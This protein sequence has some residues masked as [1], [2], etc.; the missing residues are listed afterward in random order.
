MRTGIT[1]LFREEADV[2]AP[3]QDEGHLRAAGNGH[4]PL[5]GRGQHHRGHRPR[6]FLIGA[7]KLSISA[8]RSSWCWSLLALAV[9]FHERLSRRGQLDRHDRVDPCAEAASG[10]GDGPR[11]SMSWPFSS[12]TSAVAD[13]RQ[14][15]H[16][17]PSS[18]TH[19]I[20][21]ALVGAIAWN[22]ITWYY[23]IP[24]SSSHAL[25]GGLVGAALVKAGPA[26]ADLERPGQDRP[27]HLCCA[28]AG[29]A[30]GGLIM[31]GIS[32]MLQQ[33][34]RRRKVDK[35]FAPLQLLSAAAYSLGH[36]GNDAQKP[37]ASSGCC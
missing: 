30:L 10:R 2:R 31:V 27:V 3:D 14:G 11:S 33:A 29:F 15:H 28:A 17:S 4:R 26:F 37:S 18:T 13:D 36:G 24:S 5:R 20:F 35:I 21:G 19:V 1:K 16:R 12:F 8:C 34:R 22:V 6:K 7:C 23:G 25:I 32:W 9:R